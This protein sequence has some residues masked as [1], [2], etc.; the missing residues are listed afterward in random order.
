MLVDVVTNAK[1]SFMA[2]I[3][4]RGAAISSAGFIQDAAAPLVN[5]YRNEDCM[6]LKTIAT[7]A[8]F[9]PVTG[10]YAT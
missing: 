1:G 4:P 10:Y 2:L 8:D 6:L 5:I 3:M 7:S 9:D